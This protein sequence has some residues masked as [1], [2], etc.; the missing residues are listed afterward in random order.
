MLKIQ[1]VAKQTGVTVR[2]LHH[3]DTIG[4]LRPA[5]VTE[6]G[7]RL[8]DD[9]DLLRL[10][11]ILFF[12]ELDFPLADIRQM[13]QAPG[14]DRADA[15]RR[16]RNLLALKRQRLDG[17]IA[18][19]DETLQGGTNMKFEAFDQTAYEEAKARY[20][21]EAKERWGG[22][23][24]YRQSAAREKGRTKEESARLAAEGRGIL[25][26]FGKLVGTDPAGGQAQALVARWQE[27]I[28]AAYY[29]CTREILAGLGQM[30]VADE[31]FAGSIDQN[32]AGTA[33]FLSQAIAIYCQ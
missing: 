19:V 16:H 23:E 31:R 12:R 11:E 29:D 27:H 10:Q 14:Y 24:A 4:L 7:Y 1:Q 20:A 32:G 21:Q 3:Y 6:A 22:T 26:E 25:A 2:A 13:L 8:Y 30:Y 18:L 33:A 15:L 5:A 17:I 9:A 28:S